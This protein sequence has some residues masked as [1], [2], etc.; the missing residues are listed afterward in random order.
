MNPDEMDERRWGPEVMQLN[1]RLLSDDVIESLLNAV[2][3]SMIGVS[4]MGSRD[5]DW[6]HVFWRGA[7]TT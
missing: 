5:D 7:P 6:L 1:A 3:E 2:E 4:V